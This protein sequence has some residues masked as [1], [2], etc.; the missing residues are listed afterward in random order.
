[1]SA[2]V[3]PLIIWTS[4]AFMLGIAAGWSLARFQVV[5][6]KAPACGPFGPIVSPSPE[7]VFRRAEGLL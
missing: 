7:H 1:M 4:L 2:F 6:R 5:E 3:F